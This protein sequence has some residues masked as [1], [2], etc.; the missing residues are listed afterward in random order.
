MEREI[1]GMGEGLWRFFTEGGP[2]LLNTLI[3]IGALLA[4]RAIAGHFLRRRQRL[5]RQM[6]RRIQDQLRLGLLVIG[7]IGIVII[8]APELR[9]FALSLTVVAAAI[10]IATKELLMCFAGAVIRGSG[11]AAEPGE[12]VRIG[13]HRGEVL[14]RHLLT[15]T[16]LEVG[17]GSQIG[18]YTGRIVTLPNSVFLTSP[19]KRYSFVGD[20]IR[21]S[22]EFPLADEVDPAAAEK[23]LREI[24]AKAVT[25]YRAQAEAH[26]KR[27]AKRTDSTVFSV[28]PELN[29]HL[30]AA[31]QA[32]LELGVFL[33]VSAAAEVEQTLLR[34]GFSLLRRLKAE[35]KAAENLA[36]NPDS[37]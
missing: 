32:V 8:W 27:L 13:E 11:E 17:Q 21:H 6:K 33:P 37:V 15:T 35:A 19:V 7:V 25:P 16:L 4:I 20:F 10:A 18:R 31:G 3:L 22:V 30:T 12:V 24:A 34:E 9:T 23:G 14:E 29:L 26:A 5:P 36:K 28:E 2:Q 1:A